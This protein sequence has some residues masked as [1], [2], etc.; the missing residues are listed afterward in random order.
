MGSRVVPPLELRMERECGDPQPR[1]P[2]PCRPLGK[3]L[4]M[5]LGTRAQRPVA[6]VGR[7]RVPMNARRSDGRSTE[8]PMELLRQPPAAPG[9]PAGAAD[10]G[11]PPTRA[12]P[13]GTSRPRGPG[14]A[15]C[16]EG[17]LVGGGLAGRED[18]HGDAVRG[19]EVRQHTLPL[20]QLR[21]QDRVPQ[22]PGAEVTGQVGAPTRP[23]DEDMRMRGQDPPELQRSLPSVSVPHLATGGK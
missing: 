13:S 2:P 15:A 14:P 17:P 11:G 12:S 1:G 18:P 7:T 4:G 5:E 23:S 22:V 19:L 8:R 3:P 21:L 6:Y 20:R 9:T 16:T 10:G